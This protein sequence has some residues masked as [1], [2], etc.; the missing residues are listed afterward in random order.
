MVVEATKLL[1][2]VHR[3]LANCRTEKGER[4][5]A[6]ERA[7]LERTLAS[8]VTAS[9]AEALK[10]GIS[11]SDQITICYR[12]VFPNLIAIVNWSNIHSAKLTL[13]KFCWPLPRDGDGSPG[14]DIRTVRDKV[15][16]NCK[17][18]LSNQDFCLESVSPLLLH[19]IYA[20]ACE[21][22]DHQIDQSPH[23]EEMH[24]LTTTLRLLGRRWRLASKI[25]TP[26]DS[27]LIYGFNC[28][29][30]KANNFHRNISRV[31]GSTRDNE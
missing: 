18:I 25:H 11:I 8:L 15:V 29:Y 22:I 16:A 6:E 26:F 21:C 3:Q 10:W 24:I 30:K 2:Q 14:M 31:A 19:S 7:Q 27:V 12:L 20:T 4:E 5:G 13:Y 23:L 17:T 9:E 28:G 1:G